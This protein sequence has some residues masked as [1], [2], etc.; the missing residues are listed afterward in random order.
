MSSKEQFRGALKRDKQ[1]IT[2]L[3]KAIQV[4]DD[5]VKVLEEENLRLKLKHI[6]VTRKKK[7]YQFWK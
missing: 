1:L 6:E 4:R 3:Q 2:N 7:W 5:Y